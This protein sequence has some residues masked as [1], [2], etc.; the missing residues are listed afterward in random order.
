[1][2]AERIFGQ[3][4]VWSDGLLALLA[5]E[6]R[7]LRYEAEPVSE[8]LFC[9]LGRSLWGDSWGCKWCKRGDA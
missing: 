3:G 2:N 7:I 4:G 8:C 1:M 5:G 9:K 6:T